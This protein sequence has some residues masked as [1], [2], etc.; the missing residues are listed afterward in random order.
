LETTENVV[1]FSWRFCIKFLSNPKSNYRMSFSSSQRVRIQFFLG[2]TDEELS[3]THDIPRWLVSEADTAHSDRSYTKQFLESMNPILKQRESACKSACGPAC[4]IC[5][6]PTRDILQ[7][8]M[9][10]L[11]RKQDPFVGVWVSPLCGNGKCEFLTRKD[12]WETMSEVGGG[13]AGSGFSMATGSVILQ[14]VWENT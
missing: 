3:V 9:S 6:Q 1:P 11:Q 14:M 5:G 4:G 13:T 10:W 8:P 7:T 2:T 12:I